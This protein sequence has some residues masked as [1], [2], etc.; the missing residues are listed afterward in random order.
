MVTRCYYSDT[1][2]DFIANDRT[3]ILGKLASANEFDLDLTQRDAWDREI[4]ILKEILVP[5]SNRGSVYF[6]YNIP[7]MGSRIDVVLLIDGIVFVLEFKC[8]QTEYLRQDINQVWDYALDLKNFHEASHNISIVPVLVATLAQSQKIAFISAKDKVYVPICSNEN[9]LSKII[10]DGLLYA[11]KSQVQDKEW[12]ISRYSP[13]PTIIE[14]AIALYTNKTVEGITRSDASAE[15]IKKT[16][17]KIVEVID[18]CKANSKKAICFV[19]GVPGAGKTLIGLNTAIQQ[20]EKS[21]KAVY[22]SGNFPLV[23]V[24]TEALARDLKRKQPNRPKKE[25]ISEVK[26]FIQMIHNYR[27]ECLRGTKIKNNQIVPDEEY[28]LSEDNKNRSYAPI[29]HIAIFD[30]AQRSWTKAQLVNFMKRKKHVPDFPYS[31]SEYLISCLDRHTDWAVIICLVG[32]GQEINT[33]EA[34]ISEWIKALNTRFKDWQIYISDKLT[35]NEYMAG[36]AIQSIENKSRI[37][38]ASTLHLAVSMRSFRAENLSNFVHALL[39]LDVAAAK[40]IF[41]SLQSYPIVLT[42]SLET[43]RRW[44]KDK[45]RGDERFGFIASSQADRI[46]PLSLNVRYKPDVVHWFL[47]DNDDVRSSNYLEDVVTEFDV[48]GLEV[49]W[50]C[51]VWDA[52]FRYT[53]SGWKNYSFNG[54]KKWV[55]ISKPERKEFQKNAYRVLLTRARQGMI[56]CIPEGTSEDSTRKP[57]YYNSTFEYL[58]SLGIPILNENKEQITADC[59]LVAADSE[60]EYKV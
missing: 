49:D 13:T 14:A 59:G 34:G 55:N 1:I 29:D 25:I 7:R 18:H 38:V 17:E 54:G 51:V 52:D 58:E 10:H 47:D 2:K 41:L 11:E 8:G 30:E 43:A 46:K 16:S 3:L 31:E 23:A 32:G 15:N 12:E 27:D 6:E 35:E 33:G 5:Y 40:S 37:N 26:T 4:Q 53:K 9:M 56:I 21:E 19:T 22:L 42:R 45:A 44:L 28:F 60:K 50:S 57:E 20:F 48:Q 36:E 39:G 24:L